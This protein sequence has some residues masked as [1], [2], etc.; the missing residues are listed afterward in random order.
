[1]RKQTFQK[2]AFAVLAAAAALG[3]TVAPVSAATPVSAA[4]G[5]ILQP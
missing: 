3:A 5:F 2:L 4:D 1:M